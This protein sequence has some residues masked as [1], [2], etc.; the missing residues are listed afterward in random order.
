MRRKR[1]KPQRA[2]P[3]SLDFVSGHVWGGGV[4]PVAGLVGVRNRLG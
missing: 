3:F 2:P 1:L 4:V